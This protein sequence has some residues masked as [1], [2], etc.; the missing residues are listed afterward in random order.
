L[1]EAAVDAPRYG[2]SKNRKCPGSVGQMN[3]SE[4]KQSRTGNE[5]ETGKKFN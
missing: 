3:G 1:K 5:N 4:E 2:F